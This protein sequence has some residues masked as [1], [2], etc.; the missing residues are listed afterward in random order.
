MPIGALQHLRK[1]H[2]GRV[3]PARRPGESWSPGWPMVY[4]PS[5]CFRSFA[6]ETVVRQAVRQVT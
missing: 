6:T 1:D 5:R 3:R 2:V 4:L